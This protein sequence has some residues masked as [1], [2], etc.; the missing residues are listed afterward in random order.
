[1]FHIL[2]TTYCLGYIQH[3]RTIKLVRLL[4]TDI[5]IR[6]V[7][8]RTQINNEIL[9][10]CIRLHQ[11]CNHFVILQ[12]DDITIHLEVHGE[13][14]KVFWLGDDHAHVEETVV[15]EERRA[16][17]KRGHQMAGVIFHQSIE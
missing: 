6:I 14:E 13:V 15:T 17:V 10:V 11:A 12:V 5:Q 7:L 8:L 4:N 3:H 2:F 16:T 1:M 9:G